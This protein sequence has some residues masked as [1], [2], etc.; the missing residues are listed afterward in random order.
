MT[1]RTLQLL[2]CA[3]LALAPLG[4]VCA[5]DKKKKKDKPEENGIEWG[6][7]LEGEVLYDT[8]IFNLSESQIDRLEDDRAADEISGRFDDME[9]PDDVIISPRA[10]ISLS[11]PL[12]FDRDFTIEPSARYD[13]YVENPERNHARAGLDLEQKLGGGHSIGVDL[14]YAHEVFRKNYLADATDLVDSVSDDERV[15]EPGIYNDATVDL[16]YRARLWKADK[17]TPL[18]RRAELKARAGYG[19]RRYDDPFD[20]RDRDLYRAGV[21]LEIELTSF[22]DIEGGYLFE[23]LESPGDEEVL[24]RDEP[25]FGVDL[26]GDLDANDLDIRTEQKVDRTRFRH[27][28]RADVHLKGDRWSLKVGY[29][30]RFEDFE[31]D[32]LFDT[33]YRGREDIRHE[34]RVA[35]IRKIGDSFNFTLEGRYLKE[36]STSD[37]QNDNEEREYERFIVGATLTAKF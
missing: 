4:E 27:G 24:I 6:L 28:F 9:S 22:L 32:E 23:Y 5:K 29:R 2:L 3:L 7:R 36:T 14:G 26:N 8:N 12:L 31:S 15:Y 11:F 33:T 35:L 10:A 13:F 34:A 19:F 1:G 18:L 20:N 30:L 21:D 37:A 25:E 17:D 16:R